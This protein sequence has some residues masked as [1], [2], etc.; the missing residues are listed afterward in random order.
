MMWD[1]LSHSKDYTKKELNSIISKVRDMELE[2]ERMTV[3]T[4][5]D[6]NLS[7]DLDSYV[8]EA[9]FYVYAYNVIKEKRQWFKEG[10]S[11]TPEIEKLMP[12]DLKGRRSIMSKELFDAMGLF[13][14]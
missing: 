13:F 3:G 5:K 12:K 11:L 2:C 4:I 1:W 9:N 10:Y 7:I 8:C 6:F 14:S